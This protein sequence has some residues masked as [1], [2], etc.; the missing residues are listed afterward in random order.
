MARFK[1]LPDRIEMRPMGDDLLA[2]S[3]MQELLA[4]VGEEPD[5]P[6]AGRLSVAAYP[7]DGD[8]QSEYERLMNPELDRQR[9]MDRDA[10]ASVLQA[11]ESGTV[12]L[13]APEAEALL[14]VLNEARL[15]LGARLGIVDDGWDSGDRR[16]SDPVALL[17]RYLTGYQDDLVRALAKRF[18]T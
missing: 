17:L 13:T 9:R 2:L 5:D 15:A 12:D 10:V 7:Q 14:M 11:A 16:A 8:A 4:S 3:L 1:V 18:E 6:A